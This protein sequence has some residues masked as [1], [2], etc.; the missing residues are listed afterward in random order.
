MAMGAIEQGSSHDE[1]PLTSLLS[2]RKLG[3]LFDRTGA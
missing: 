2:L 3:T 1:L